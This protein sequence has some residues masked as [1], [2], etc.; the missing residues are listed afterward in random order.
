MTEASSSAGAAHAPVTR[1][2]AERWIGLDALRG[3]AILS[4]ILVNNPGDWGKVYAPLLHAK[5]HGCTFTDLVFPTFLFCAGVSIVP[6]LGSSLQRG[7]SRSELAMRAW[8]RCAML[9]LLGLFVASFPVLSFEDG[10]GLFDRVL[11]VR[12]PGVLQRIGVCYAIAAMLFLFAS[13]RAQR[14]ILVASLVLYWPL[15]ALCPTPDGGAPDLATEGD[16]LAGFLD[17]VVFG[18]HT[19][20]G[21][22]YDPEGLLST[23]PA[24]GTALLGVECGRVLN[25]PIVREDAVRRLLLLGASWMAVGAVWGWFLPINKALWTSSYVMW[26]GGIAA[27][28]LGLFVHAFEVRGH[29]RFAR[30]LLVYGRNALLVFVGSAVLARTIG[31]L[32]FVDAGPPAVSLQKWIFTNGFA[33]W[34]EPH[35]ASLGF[36]LAWVAGWYVV[37]A[38]LYRRGIIWRV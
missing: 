36:A 18:S 17:R 19:W 10:K 16:H 1:G 25:A 2:G 15:L 37:L 20:M 33:N 22:V 24:V 32:V 12:F 31:R 34:L 4:M 9:V 23:I 5:W 8:K 26:T 13:V 14:A 3:L 7:R 30:P 28:G 11:S 29:A 35:M 27:S 38:V 21:K 6:A